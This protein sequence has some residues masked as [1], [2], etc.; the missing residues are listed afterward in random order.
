MP[1]HQ[2][3]HLSIQHGL[4]HYLTEPLKISLASFVLAPHF[5]LKCAEIF[6]FTNDFKPIRST[7]KALAFPALCQVACVFH[8]S[9]GSRQTKDKSVVIRQDLFIQIMEISSQR[10]FGA[11]VLERAFV[12]SQITSAIHHVKSF[13]SL[14]NLSPLSQP[15]PCICSYPARIFSARLL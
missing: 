9:L 12:F 4:P 3:L 6:L 11:T 7:C 2:A 14:P 1:P 13:S 15:P 5:P 10:F 8:E